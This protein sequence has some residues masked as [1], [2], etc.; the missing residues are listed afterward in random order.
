M[1]QIGLETSAELR[2]VDYGSSSLADIE[3]RPPDVR[4][5][6]ETG[7]FGA[8]LAALPPPSPM[9]LTRIKMKNSR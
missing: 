6:S 7:H 9:A 5:A 2:R 8:Q 4:F 1:T 3:S